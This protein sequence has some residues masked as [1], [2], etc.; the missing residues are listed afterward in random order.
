ML[1]Q[2]IDPEKDL[3]A[4]TEWLAIWRATT[5]ETFPD[6]VGWDERD[7]RAMVATHGS[8]GTE[9]LRCCDDT[10]TTVGAA[11]L[12]VPLR[13]NRHSIWTD[14]R[15][16]AKQRWCGVGR[17]LVEAV[18]RRARADGRTVINGI[19]DVP[20]GQSDSHPSFPFAQAMGFVSTQP[21]HRRHLTL[22]VD[23]V[24]R[25]RLQ[26]D[27]DAARGASEYRIISLVGTWP[28]EFTED[29][30]ALERAMSTDQP[31]GDSQAEEEVWDAAR[32]AEIAESMERQGLNSLVSAAQHIESGRLV[33][34]SRIAVA[35]RRPTEAWQWATIVLHEH[36]G[37]RLGL[38][39]K[40]ANLDL[41]ASVMPDARR[42]LTSNAAV[43]AP[44]IA[45]N[46]MMGFEIDAEGTFW[47][48]SLT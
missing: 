34:Y 43:N 23:A 32:I 6:D 37:H 18:E 19:A 10:G 46:D 21:G 31:L 36:R 5:A 47:K 11:L 29:Q 20:V 22:P 13:D 39:V 4:F 40:L 27:V 1:V 35:E 2:P 7:I 12:Q 26:Q 16:D 15:V 8:M 30:C 14:L 42:L 38:A 9:L 25:Q 28:D 24:L 48:K 41:L 3:Q 45:V 44:M 33:A 17:S